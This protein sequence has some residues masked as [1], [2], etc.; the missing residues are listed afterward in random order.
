MRGIYL[1]PCDIKSILKQDLENKKELSRG[2]NSS[3]G[4]YD[5]DIIRR[6]SYVGVLVGLSILWIY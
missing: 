3:L 4:L 2:L 1:I 5:C 6:D